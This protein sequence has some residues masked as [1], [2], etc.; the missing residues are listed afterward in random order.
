MYPALPSNDRLHPWLFSPLGSI[1]LVAG[2]GWRIGGKARARWPLGGIDES[3]AR[4]RVIIDGLSDGR[5]G[6]TASRRV[7]LF[8]AGICRRGTG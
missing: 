6:G 3:H 8:V 2:A 5:S 4:A 7:G 1:T